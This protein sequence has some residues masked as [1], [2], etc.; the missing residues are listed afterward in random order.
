M[1]HAPE[2]PR[3]RLLQRTTVLIL[4]K[5]LVELEALEAERGRLRVALTEIELWPVDVNE[6]PED[7][8][9]AIKEHARAALATGS[10]E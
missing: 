2:S 4:A 9:I 1:S 6:L 8:L 10:T 3:G 5:V 7:D